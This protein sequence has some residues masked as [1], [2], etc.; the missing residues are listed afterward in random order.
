MTNEVTYLNPSRITAVKE[1]ARAPRGDANSQGYG[2][3]MGTHTMV[4][5]DGKRWHR[6]YV[7]CWSNAGTRYVV[8]NGK[9]QY[10]ATSFEITAAV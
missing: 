4:Q 7:V 2:S 1:T 3:K 8:T 6:V 10:I 5:L 9:A